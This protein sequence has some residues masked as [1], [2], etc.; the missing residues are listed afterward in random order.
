MGVPGRP[1]GVV[2]AVTTKEQ[3][4]VREF[5]GDAYQP[6]V[7]EQAVDLKKEIEQLMSVAELYWLH[8]SEKER[9]RLSINQDMY[10]YMAEEVL[11]GLDAVGYVIVEK[12]TS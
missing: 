10:A 12:S 11:G 2:S 4:A 6:P 5:L 7:R 3:W 8:W 9:E 1:G